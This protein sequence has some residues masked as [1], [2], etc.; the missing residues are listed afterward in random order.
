MGSSFFCKRTDSNLNDPT[1]VW[2]TVAFDLAR[3]DRYFAEELINNLNENK[4]IVD[5]ADIH[6]HFK[7][8]IEEPCNASL[9]RRA[10]EGRNMATKVRNIVMIVTRIHLIFGVLG[11]CY[12]CNR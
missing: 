6:S 4:S 2:R 8:F 10:Q 11:R 9:R 12:G 5:R 7:Y 1:A 3:A